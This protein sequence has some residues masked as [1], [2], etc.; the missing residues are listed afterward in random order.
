MEQI[1]RTELSKPLYNLLR[2]LNATTSKDITRLTMTGIHIHN[3]QMVMESTNGYAVARV[4]LDLPCELKI[5]PGIWHIETLT[6]KTVILQKIEGEFPDTGAVVNLENKMKLPFKEDGD[7]AISPK[8]FWNV[9]KGM[10]V[11]QMIIKSNKGP[12]LI[13]FCPVDMPEGEYC[14]VIMPMW[15]DSVQ[16]ILNTIKYVWD[17]ESE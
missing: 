13:N 2:W 6:K 7:I 3:N 9:G 16:M 11:A 12:I 1:S 4:K 17:K 14:G 8:L 5:P 10:Q 15:G